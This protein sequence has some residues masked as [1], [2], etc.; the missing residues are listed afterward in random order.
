ML[1]RDVVVFTISL[2]DISDENGRTLIHI[3]GKNG[4]RSSLFVDLDENHEEVVAAPTGQSRDDT[5]DYP[6]KKPR[7]RVRYL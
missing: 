3:E 2:T 1:Q 7:K 5:G 6:I 4:R